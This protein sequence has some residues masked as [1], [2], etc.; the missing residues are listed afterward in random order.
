M[1]GHKSDNTVDILLPADT[2]HYLHCSQN[3]LLTHV[4]WSSNAIQTARGSIPPHTHTHTTLLLL[5]TFLV[6][7]SKARVSVYLQMIV[8]ND[9]L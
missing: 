3:N 1:E 2:A 5:A 9:S 8:L 4:G 7:S 6:Q